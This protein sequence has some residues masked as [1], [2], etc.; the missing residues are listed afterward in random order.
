MVGRQEAGADHG[1]LGGVRVTGEVELF[2]PKKDPN[3]NLK[4]DRFQAAPDKP[5]NNAAL[6]SAKVTITRGEAGHVLLV[7]PGKP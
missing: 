2:I 7:L 6:K 5:I 3:T 4:L 1:L